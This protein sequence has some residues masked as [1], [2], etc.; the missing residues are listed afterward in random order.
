MAR[1][2]SFKPIEDGNAEVLILG[3]M[4][5]RKS[6]AAGQYYAH[7][8]NA[9]W[10]I[11]AELLGFDPAA[12]Y[13]ARIQALRSSRIALWDVLRSC[14]RE[15][16]LDSEIENGSQTANDFRAFFRGH[17]RIRHVY[18]NGAKSEECFK[19]HVL[20]KLDLNGIRCSRLP[21]TSPAHAA[22]S[23]ARKLKAWRAILKQT[24]LE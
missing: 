16:S 13:E 17:R 7:P 15:G 2:R 6:L 9:F 1:V 19:R 10:R 22:M 24:K 3:S 14:T 5:G 8:H 21:S 23:F 4:P 12:S 20:P 18:F 11:M